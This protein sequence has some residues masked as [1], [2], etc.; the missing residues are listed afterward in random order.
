VCRLVPGNTLGRSSVIKGVRR[1]GLGRVQVVSELHGDDIA[2]VYREQCNRLR[3]VA[4]LMTGRRETAE[5]IVQEAFARAQPRCDGIGTPAAYLRT[6]VVNLCAEQRRRAG[7][8]R[9]HGPRLVD[10]QVDP[11]EIDETWELLAGLPLHQ[12]VV[13]V[14]RYYEDLPVDAIAQ[15]GGCRPAT[16]RTRIHRALSKLRKEMTP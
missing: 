1:A 5:E 3:R 16:V 10:E 6:V 13:L 14:L 11:P 12:R 4:Y 15:I 7:L 9:E 2:G 8:E